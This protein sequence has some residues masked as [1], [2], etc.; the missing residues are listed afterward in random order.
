MK[1]RRFAIVTA[2]L[3]GAALAGS[4]AE[5]GRLFSMGG[6]LTRRRAAVVC[7]IGAATAAGLILRPVLQPPPAAPH[8]PPDRTMNYY[9]VVQKYRGGRPFQQPFPL[10]KE[11][12]FPPDYRIRLMF[13]S[14]EPGYLYLINEGPVANNGLPAYNVL[15]PSPFRG[16]GSALL[17]PNQEIPIPSENDFFV[18]DSQQGDEKIWLVWA[19]A[20]VPE[21]EAVK[22]WVNRRDQDRIKD[23]LQAGAV[24]QFL[25]RHSERSPQVEKDEKNVR[26][27]VRGPGDVL[28]GLVRLE[29]D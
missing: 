20:S 22:S 2:F 12:L 17:R 5:S 1:R 19:K 15:F 14:P 7:A 4:G 26:T 27:V 18:F 23:P 24:K 29:H 9:V 25:A 10:A 16:S 11:M 8:A 6:L 28:V 21:M 3:C 13:N